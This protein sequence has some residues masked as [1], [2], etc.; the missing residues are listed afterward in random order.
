MNYSQNNEQHIIQE[1]FGEEKVNFADFG[2]NDGITYS[3]TYA[4]VLKGCKGICVEASEEAFKR[5]KNNYKDYSENIEFFN[6]AVTG[7]YEGDL[8]LFESGSHVT[9]N[10]VSLLSTIKKD[11]V[12]RWAGTKNKFVEKTINAWPVGKI[13]EAA[14][15]HPIHLF[16]IDIEGGELDVLPHIDFTYYKTRMIIVENNGKNQHLYDNI[17]IPQ[18]FKLIHTTPENLIYGR[19]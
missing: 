1:Y 15:L 18:G 14:N 19:K 7:E 9:D 6:V 17:I 8:T 4:L 2:C 10:D 16:S 3:N 12:K 11:E 5:L 13:L